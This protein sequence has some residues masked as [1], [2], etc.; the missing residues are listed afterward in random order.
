MQQDKNAPRIAVVENT[1]MPA[2]EMAAQFSKPSADLAGPGKRK[3][4]SV[5]FQELE[6]LRNLA[7]FSIGKALQKR[8]NR[9]TSVG[10]DV[11]FI[12]LAH[13]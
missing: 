9:N 13:I 4:R 11:E 1:N 8:A 2:A 3:R 7:K 6:D 10:L 12:A 5:G